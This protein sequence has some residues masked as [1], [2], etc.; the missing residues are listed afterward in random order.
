[1]KRSAKDTLQIFFFLFG[2]CVLVACSS[3]RNTA[4]NRAL[5]NLSA[6]YNYLYN[7]N[8]L[9][10]D[11]E[12]QFLRDHRENYDE[13]L[14]IFRVPDSSAAAADKSLATIITKAQ[15]IIADK[16]VSNYLDEAYVL[17]GKANFY[18]GNYFS[19]SGYFDYVAKTYGK[20]IKIKLQALNWKARS[21]FALH[22]KEN[23][24]RLSDTLGMLLAKIKKHKSPALATLAQF[25]VA[26]KKYDQAIQLLREALKNP[27][28]IVEKIRWNYILGQLYEQ[29][30]NNQESLRYYGKVVSSNA[31][32]DMYFNANLSK[33]NL[34]SALKG[35]RLSRQQQIL[36]LLKD[37]KNEG[38]SDQ[39]Y[40]KAAESY[41]AQ[42]DWK[43]AEK[44]YLLSAAV[45]S[46][47]SFQKGLSFL[48]LADIRF[49]NQSYLSAKL[50]Y[51]SAMMALPKNYPDYKLVENKAK[52][53]QYLSD[54]FKIIAFQDTAQKIANLP[55]ADRT[56]AATTYLRVV[57]EADKVA[58]PMDVPLSNDPNDPFNVQS[59]A[60]TFYFNNP[61]AIGTG[62][63]DF[64]RKWGNRPLEDNWRQSTR[65][66]AQTTRQ[67]QIAGIQSGV[68]PNVLLD[69]AST[70]VKNYLK[71][72][73]VTEEMIK[74]SNQ[75]IINAY[76]E[77]GTFYQ[78]Q[79]NDKKEAIRIFELLLA[80]F[81]TANKRDAIMYSLYRSYDGL[82]PQNAL[83]YKNLIVKDF[84]N[85][86]YAK[87]IV[88]PGYSIR[89]NAMEL[90]V[91]KDY[92]TVYQAYENKNY[93]LVVTGVNNA[94]AKY[95]KNSLNAQYEYLKAIAIGRTN[96]VDSLL[97]VFTKIVNTYP[98]DKVIIPLIQ[99]HISYIVAH[100]D[101]FRQRK[102]ALVDFDTNAARFIA[103]EPIIT[104][105]PTI[106]ITKAVAPETATSPVKTQSDASPVVA[107]TKPRFKT[108]GTFTNAP[109]DIYYYVVDVSDASLTL[110]SSRFGIGQFNRGNYSDNNFKHQLREFDDDQLIYVGNFPDLASVKRYAE[111]INTQLKSIMKVPAAKYRSFI[112]TQENFEKITSRDKINQYLTFYSNSY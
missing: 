99:D 12:I 58:A 59:T 85:S 19:A 91:Q 95:P 68:T 43:N 96:T 47:N 9:L 97:I 20:D 54:R 69:T 100:I 22:D 74:A 103:Q 60:T 13:I 66:A 98:E 48:R 86:T 67:V 61:T 15:A 79:L 63:S 55:I 4:S 92:N 80:R 42:G 90:A 65:T 29:Q 111:I 11:Y 52:N 23:I 76:F 31:P 18:Q 94:L 37:D 49:N 6:R 57:E 51:D 40:Y 78:L 106:P 50:Y 36:A 110:S 39:I 38:Y 105:K 83:L 109:S 17:L 89:E 104:S 7:A 72:L 5:Q 87:S 26:D 27:P 45:G 46:Q 75:K 1:M 44:Y 14:P 16:N 77:I 24:T 56:A 32:F 70:N 101:E 21:E 108:D 10:Y 88:D 62:Y 3:E 93:S 2:I 30:N 35:N 102:V 25:A 84:P 34:E 71:N 41:A 112:V 28:S 82:D 81:P 64:L 73:P 8:N 107:E 33:I 53:L